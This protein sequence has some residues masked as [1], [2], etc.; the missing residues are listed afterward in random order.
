M[1]NDQWQGSQ[2]CSSVASCLATLFWETPKMKSKGASWSILRKHTH[3]KWRAMAFHLPST[4]QGAMCIAALA[5]H[6]DSPPML[7]DKELRN[8]ETE[9]SS[10]MRADR[11]S[12]NLV[13]RLEDRLVLLMRYSDACIDHG[14]FHKSSLGL[15][16]QADASFL[17]S[18]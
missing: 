18:E 11:C 15:G 3:L 13:K 6:T 4:R 14:E 5:L 9:A 17:R 8:R 2:L 1:L 7:F 16:N 12:R 10:F